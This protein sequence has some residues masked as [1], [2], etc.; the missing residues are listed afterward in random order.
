MKTVQKL[1]PSRHVRGRFLVWFEGERD[2]LKVTDNEVVAFALSPGRTLEPQELARLKEAGGLSSA[3]ALGARMLG[4]RPLSRRELIRLLEEKG[5]APENAQA[6]ADWL[7]ELGALNELEYARSIVRHYTTR[8]YGA[9]KLR[10][11]F[12]RRGVPRELWGPGPGGAVRPR[13]TGWCPFWIRSSGARPRTPNYSSAPLTPCCGGD[14]VGRRSRPA[15]PG[16]A[17]KS[18]R[19]PFERV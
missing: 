10:Q 6:A 15:W 13:W 9:Q 7:E 19:N 4:E 18:R 3:K 11:E 2:P 14:S 17:R 16:T 5:T 1:E 12:Q 8:G